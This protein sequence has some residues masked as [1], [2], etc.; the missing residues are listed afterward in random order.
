MFK[1]FLA[2]TLSGTTLAIGALVGVGT[3][4]AA[5]IG[6]STCPSGS[7]DSSTLG[8]PSGVHAGMNGAALWRAVDNNVFS[9]R[10]SHASGRPV[11]YTGSITTD[12]VLVYVPRHLE[13]GDVIRRRSRH[14]IVFAM[15][16][17]GHL[18]GLD[19]APLCA[20]K[21]TLHLKLNGS[22]LP[23]S[24]IVIG[25]SNVNPTSNPFTETKS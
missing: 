14:T 21:V 2:T 16:N 20:S 13:R 15:T 25:S 4:A 23:T 5:P 12:G 8:V 10:V 18:D 3:A 19:F 24:E 17:I 9:L 11:L 7:W 1:R 6:A 22:D